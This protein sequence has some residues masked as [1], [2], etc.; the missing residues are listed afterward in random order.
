MYAPVNTASLNT[1]RQG[2]VDANGHMHTIPAGSGG[3]S[4]GAGW[5]GSGG[6]SFGSSAGAGLLNCGAINGSYTGAGQG[7]G[8]LLMNGGGGDGCSDQAC[9]TAACAGPLGGFCVSAGE[10]CGLGGEVGCTQTT[11]VG[12]RL[13][14]VGHTNGDWVEV[15][16]YR[17][18]GSGAGNLAFVA[19]ART[20]WGCC[21]T[22]IALM[23][24][25]IAVLAFMWPSGT[26]ST[27]TFYYAF[28]TQTPA[29]T[30]LPVRRTCTFWGDPHII[31]FDGARPSFYGDG[32]YWI[33]KNDEVKIQGRYVGTPWTYGLAATQKVAVGGPFLDGHLIEV[34]PMEHDYGGHI[35]VDREPVLIHFG[36]ITVGNGLASIRY[37][38][39]GV[40]P[41]SAAGRWQKHIVHMSLPKGIELTVFRWANYLDLTIEME[42]LAG[43]QDGS[44]GNF[45]RDA[46]DDT[47]QAI[48]SRIG[49]RVD[50]MELLFTRQ[51]E[52]VFTQEEED[53]LRLQ[54]SADNL[55]KGERAC[56]QELPS[57]AP[58]KEMNACVFDECFGM[59][60][61]A[62]RT[63]KTLA[64]PADRA[65]AG[66]R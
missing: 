22:V 19:K 50:P 30:P 6:G 42:P 4:S 34:E 1:S 66:E 8:L 28:R 48:F 54:C 18:V 39:T 31:T 46:S 65:A 23:L 11:S 14:D 3:Y 53:M 62:L 20:Y 26:S 35:L 17:Y 51:T 13:H 56:R 21:L 43:G 49:A 64:S 63:A 40:L 59:N 32:E 44:C 5:A 38:S 7:G 27:T 41:D 55:V 52:V 37:D 58:V 45:N 12:G 25:G 29:T 16:A 36:Q 24:L 60:A 10:G 2:W 47:D 33:V 61:H 9:G 15:V 57:T